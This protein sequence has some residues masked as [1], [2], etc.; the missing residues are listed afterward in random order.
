MFENLAG[1]TYSTDIYT[2]LFNMLIIL[3]VGGLWLM[4][5]RNMKRQKNVESMLTTASAQLEEASQHLEIALQEIKRL[6]QTGRPPEATP[7][8]NDSHTRKIS[9]TEEY[10]RAANPSAHTESNSPGSADT[11]VQ[12]IIQMHAQGQTAEQI[13]AHL[14]APLARVKLLLRLNEQRQA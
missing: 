8:S 2:M 1:H 7:G 14:D 3:A 11:D 12:Q 9:G 4:W 10:Y 13:A 6:Q 5:A